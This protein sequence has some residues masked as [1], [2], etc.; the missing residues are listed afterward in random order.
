MYVR[1]V[2][3]DLALSPHSSLSC[4]PKGPSAVWSSHPWRLLSRVNWLAQ[5]QG[6]G[7]H[8]EGPKGRPSELRWVEP[9]TGVQLL[10]GSG[11]LAQV[12]QE[13]RT[14]QELPLEVSLMK[15]RTGGGL[16]GKLCL[17]A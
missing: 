9:R 13:A 3:L 1:P 7:A 5:G 16:D 11:V 8:V 12:I 15:L 4:M 2:P 14:E 6:I 17:E 10:W